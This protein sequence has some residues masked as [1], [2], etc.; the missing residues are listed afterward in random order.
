MPVSARS[1]GQNEVATPSFVGPRGVT[2]SSR[3][4]PISGWAPQQA[5]V[6]TRMLLSRAAR[7]WAPSIARALCW[8]WYGKVV[9]SELRVLVRFSFCVVLSLPPCGVNRSAVPLVCSRNYYSRNGGLLR[10][11]LY[12]S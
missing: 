1:S 9:S 2:D 12:H 11:A 8:R 6:A 4:H 3:V 5:V 10:Y 7:S